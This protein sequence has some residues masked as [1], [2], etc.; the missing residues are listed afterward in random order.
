MVLKGHPNPAKGRLRPHIWV[1]GPDPVIH[2]KYRVWIQQ[3]NQ[4]QWRGEGWTISF[5]KWCEIWADH[6][7]LRGR[8]TG[9]YCMSRL[10]WS[11]PWTADN[12][13]IITRHEHA[14]MQGQARASGWRSIA[15]KREI[16]QRKAQ[17]CEQE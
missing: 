7:H 15:R 9:D 1:T 10:D 6:W 2:K 11:L 12:V 13:A 4:A 16:A 17:Q 5:E 3:K 8:E 14:K